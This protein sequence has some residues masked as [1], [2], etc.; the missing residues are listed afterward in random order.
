MAKNT[1]KR[2]GEN[3]S[4]ET[5]NKE[6]Q[7]FFLK[8]KESMPELTEEIIKD[9]GQTIITGNNDGTVTIVNL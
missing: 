4:F 1:E 6:A 2:N 5:L 3:K 8:M 7:E 9:T